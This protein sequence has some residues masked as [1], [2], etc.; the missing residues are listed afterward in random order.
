MDWPE[1]DA[2]NDDV[3]TTTADAVLLLKHAAAHFDAQLH[4][5]P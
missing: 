4:E 5:R 3:R 2:L 1:L